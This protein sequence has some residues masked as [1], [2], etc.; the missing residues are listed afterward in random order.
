MLAGTNVP[1]VWDI[2]SAVSHAAE[3]FSIG[4]PVNAFFAVCQGAS[5][6][7]ANFIF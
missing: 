6:Q 4:P 3:K 7:T 2:Y 5:T 1:L